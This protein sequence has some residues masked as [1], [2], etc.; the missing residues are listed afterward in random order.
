MIHELRT[1]TLMPGTAPVVAKNSG[2]IARDIRDDDYGKLEGYWLTEIGALNQLTED[3]R[4]KNQ[5][6][7]R[8]GRQA[9]RHHHAQV[10][11]GPARDHSTSAT[12][13][14]PR[15]LVPMSTL[16]P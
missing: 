13:A 16:P 1:Y 4:I 2:T 11:A 10:R 12:R 5:H 6:R 15:S 9:H 7:A 14:P 8:D 3:A